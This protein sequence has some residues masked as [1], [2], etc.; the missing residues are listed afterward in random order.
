MLLYTTRCQKL[1]QSL[2][3]RK[4]LLNVAVQQLVLFQHRG[5][6]WSMQRCS[7]RGTHLMEKASSIAAGGRGPEA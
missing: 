1:F 3:D 4:R 2:L 5:K 6:A 7:G